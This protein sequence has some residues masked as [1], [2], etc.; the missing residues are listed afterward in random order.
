M[1]AGNGLMFYP[2]PNDKILEI[3]SINFADDKLKV[4]KKMNVLF[5]WVEDSVEKGEN[6]AYQHFL[7]FSQCFQKPSSIESLKVRT[8]W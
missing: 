5:Y 2:L 7:L 4:A 8:V 6:A 1:L 3:E